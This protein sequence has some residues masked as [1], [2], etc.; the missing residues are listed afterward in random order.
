MAWKFLK[1]ITKTIQSNE[2]GE[3]F[4]FIRQ[5]SILLENGHITN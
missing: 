3:Y 5:Y 1:N 2:V 4:N